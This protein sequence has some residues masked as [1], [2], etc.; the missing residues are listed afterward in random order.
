MSVIRAG[1]V[2][3]RALLVLLAA[4]AAV[5]ASRAN[6]PPAVNV[7][8]PVT[9]TLTN[10]ALVTQVQAVE[11]AES[12]AS[13]YDYFSASSHTGFETPF[14]SKLFLYRD[15]TTGALS[16]FF[17]HGIDQS[18][19]GIS[20]PA[21]RVVFDLSGVPPGTFVA[22]SDDP[23]QISRAELDLAL[24]P[25]GFWQYANN[26]DGGVLDGLPTDLPWCLT[27]TPLLFEAIDSWVYHY[28]SGAAIPLDRALPV[29]IC[30][31]PAVDLDVLDVDEGN[32]V[33]LSGSF[34]D[35]DA[36]DVH[37]ATWDFG[38]GGSAVA[39]YS[40]GAGATHHDC[41]PA[42]HAYGD[43]GSYDAVLTVDDGA[44]GVGS[45]AIEVRVRN[46]APSLSLGSAFVTGVGIGLIIPAQASDPGSDDLAFT[47]DFGDGSPE[48]RNEHFNDGVGPDGL[49]SPGGTF[50]FVAQDSVR[51][52]WCEPGTYALRVDV[53]DDDGGVVTRIAS[54]QVLAFPSGTECNEPPACDAGP[55]LLGAC[56]PLQA[57]AAASDPDGDALAYLWTSS[58]PGTSFL[59]GPD[60]LAPEVRLPEDC[61]VTC[62]LTLQVS[63]GN[64]GEC[65]DDL[66]AR[67]LDDVAPEILAC[68][69]DVT[70]E[71][72]GAG[73]GAER[74]AWLD[75]FAA[76]DACGAVTL[77][78]ES[79][80]IAACAGTTVETWTFTAT[81]ACGNA[82]SCVGQFAIADT[83]PPLL[84]GVP[85]DATVSCDAVPVPATPT[86]LD[87]CDPGAGIAFTELRTDGACPGSYLLSRTW[88]ATDGCGNEAS[89]TH[90]LTVEDRTPP[91]VS[92]SLAEIACLWPP[93]HRMAAFGRESFSPAISDDCSGPV[94][95]RFAGCASD[96]PDDGLGDGSTEADC[97]VAPDGLSFQV[98]AERQGLRP[99]GRRYGVAIIAIDACGNASAPVIAGTILVPHDQSPGADCV[100]ATGKR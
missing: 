77:S 13:F 61:D 62:V 83:T 73:N 55:D 26:T 53:E 94:T 16:L 23:F 19:S 22:Q 44:G 35:P 75:S 63:D 78:R 5:P 38:D 81:D 33:S 86:A 57:E 40:P 42:F 72:D 95:W 24:E 49:P 30:F 59:P 52:V 51:H 11:R 80:A 46:V 97:V 34:D 66:V 2:P 6:V 50:P 28:A 58:C 25:E 3:V 70:V 15:T 71:C 7:T 64:G 93:N 14:E 56:G 36:A 91:I 20:T 68:P 41:E 79:V 17:T 45:D 12:A 92:E 96:Q 98:R 18:T 85:A 69:G 82:T 65:S 47:W 48:E 31:E 29:T 10:G 89:A 21:G 37:A 100:A 67:L 88:T 84:A 27:V 4:L 8:S 90:V 60:V 43:D 87:A 32:D 99:E 54:V 74:Q 39:T 1:R 76:T 9:F